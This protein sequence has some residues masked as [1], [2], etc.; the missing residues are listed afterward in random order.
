MN[1]EFSERVKIAYK[2]LKA[3][4]YFD[5]TQLPLRDQLV[6][7]EREEIESQLN[8]LVEKITGSESDWS[9]F[10]DEIL[11]AVSA[12]VFPKALPIHREMWE[13]L[14]AME[15]SHPVQLRYPVLLRR[16]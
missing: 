11:S 4:V 7:Y 14:C 13:E 6:T 12:F 2:K 3:S 5:K 9:A 8:T 1:L 15:Q 16:G 10:V